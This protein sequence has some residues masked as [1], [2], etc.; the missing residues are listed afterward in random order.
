VDDAI[1]VSPDEF[2]NWLTP[3]QVLL[4]ARSVLGNDDAQKPVWERLH[5]EIIRAGALKSSLASP[6]NAEPHITETPTVIPAR[7]WGHFSDST[8]S[9]FWQTGVALFFFSAER[10]RVTHATVIR[11]F[12]VRLHPADV[13]ASACSL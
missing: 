4:H 13:E 9:E 2:V 12:D 8:K 1:G 6:P 5:G 10:K 11:C 7:Y 3:Q